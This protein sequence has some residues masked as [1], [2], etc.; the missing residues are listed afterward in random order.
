MTATWPKAAWLRRLRSP[1]VIA[2]LLSLALHLYVWLMS[3]LI[4]AAL[5]NG[6]LP[7]WLDRAVRP[8]AAQL[9]PT[10]N[11]P[12]P[13]PPAESWQ[14]I[15]LQFVEVDPASVTEE[16]PENTALFSTANTRAANPNPTTTDQA[17]P[18]ID[19]N[20]DDTLKTFDTLRPVEKP[21]PATPKDAVA[22]AEET[23]AATPPEP[24]V[25][26]PPV[27]QTLPPPVPLVKTEVK[28]LDKPKELTLTPP[29]PVQPQ[30]TPGETLLAKANPQ[31]RPTDPVKPTELNPPK[32]PTQT[33]PPTESA[34]QAQT[35]PVKRRPPKRLSEVMPTKGAMVGEKMRQ[36]GGV[37]RMALESSLDV[38]ASP[39]GDYHY[40]MVLAVQQR[41]Y[42]L[43]EERRFAMERIG[44][45]VIT[46]DLHSDGT[47]T[48]LATK[49]SDVGETLALLCELSVMQPAPFGRWP[50]EIRRIIGGDVIPVTFTFNYY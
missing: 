16:A 3:V 6:W 20:R 35:P 17:K 32:V 4:Q 49:N 7:P 33:A 5:K 14:E 12:T 13:A 29:E 44:K 37:S 36:E 24:E 41:W 18:R 31:A 15:P 2:L 19:G 40:R 21:Q 30:P 45:V 25:V 9:N 47:V 38:K 23:A 42:R 26:Q 46:F 48:S 11:T 22:E 50:P 10:P 28:P 1:L 39:L 27:P 34:P 43:L 8:I